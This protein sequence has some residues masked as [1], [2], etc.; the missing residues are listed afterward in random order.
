MYLA[1]VSH[2][3]VIAVNQI[4]MIYYYDCLSMHACRT[5][6][7]LCLWPARKAI[8]RWPNCCCTVGHSLTFQER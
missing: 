5:G 6:L 2:C 7:L 4:S 1:I 8:K 3:H